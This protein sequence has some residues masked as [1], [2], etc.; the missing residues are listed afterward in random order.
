MNVR[1][2][3]DKDYDTI[4]GWWKSHNMKPISKNILPDNGR[5]GIIV[6]YDGINVCAGFLYLTNSD[7][8]SIE[9]VVT[10]KNFKKNKVKNKCLDELF[11]QLIKLAKDSGSSIIF[12]SIRNKNIQKKSLELGFICSDE[13]INNYIKIL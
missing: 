3:N 7:V 12:T 1:Y 13:K 9:F 2:I 11:I 10:N 6:S 8:S 5:G 4:C